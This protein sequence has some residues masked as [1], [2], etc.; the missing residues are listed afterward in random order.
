M[1][2]SA[3]QQRRTREDLLEAAGRLLREVGYGAMSTRRVAEAAGVP[4]SQIHYHF[5]SMQGL[6]L[7]LLKAENARLLDRQTALY[8]SDMP[9]SEKWRTACRY[10]EEDLQSGYVRVLHEMMYAALSDTEIRD[11][12]RQQ[13]GGWKRLLTDVAEVAIERH[14]PIGPFTAGELAVLVG[15]SFLGL[16][17]LLLLDAVEARTDGLRAIRKV[18]D[19]IADMEGRSRND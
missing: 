6:L 8:G 18:G 15:Q 9:L 13:L 4:L 10:L 19:L 16:E 2:K 5:R 3:K 17:T 11:H 7:E 12:V 1:A 14:G